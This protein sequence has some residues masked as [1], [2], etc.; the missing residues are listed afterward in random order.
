[1]S[2]PPPYIAA[3][4][5]GLAASWTLMPLGR[6]KGGTRRSSGK[7]PWPERAGRTG[8]SPQRSTS[9][10]ERSSGSNT[11]M[12]GRAGQKGGVN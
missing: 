12:C 7:T 6:D 4:L 11:H 10:G 1:M 9:G 3:I 5:E 8:V 2:G